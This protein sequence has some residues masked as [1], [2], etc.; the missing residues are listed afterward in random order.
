MCGL[1]T[2]CLGSRLT[3]TVNETELWNYGGRSSY[4]QLFESTV[5][6]DGGNAEEA[7]AE[8]KGALP[9]LAQF[10]E[11]MPMGSMTT[12]SNVYSATYGKTALKLILRI[13]S[14]TPTYPLEKPIATVLR[15]KLCL[16]YLAFFCTEK[17]HVYVQVESCLRWRGS[18]LSLR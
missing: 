5:L 6:P 4:F 15:P 1:S 16:E 7:Y 13:K 17:S 2:I 14:N 12:M 9:T 3:L 8:I 11:I 18:R 10:D